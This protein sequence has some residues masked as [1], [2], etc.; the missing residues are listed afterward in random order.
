MG[1]GAGGGGVLGAGG[2]VHGAVNGNPCGGLN[3]PSS[4]CVSCFNGMHM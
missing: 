4:Y 1:G 3:S 2:G